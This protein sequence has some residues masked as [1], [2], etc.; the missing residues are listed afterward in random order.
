MINFPDTNNELEKE[1]GGY[2]HVF[3][4]RDIGVVDEADL[5]TLNLPRGTFPGDCIQILLFRGSFL[6]LA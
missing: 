2:E 4:L 3:V 6:I 1:V 5:E